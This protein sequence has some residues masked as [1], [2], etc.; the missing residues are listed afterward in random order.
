MTIKFFK[1]SLTLILLCLI[2][3]ISLV[4]FSLLMG[5]TSNQI[6]SVLSLILMFCFG[7]LYRS[8]W[9]G[10]ICIIF[11][12][13]MIFI[14]TVIYN[15]FLFIVFLVIAPILLMIANLIINYTRKITK[16]RDILITQ[17]N[18]KSPAYIKSNQWFEAYNQESTYDFEN[19]NISMLI[20]DTTINLTHTILPETTNIIAI[21]KAI[22]HTRIIVPIGVGISLMASSF[23]SN[24]LFDGE[25]YALK[26]EQLTLY[27]NNYIQ[28]SRKVKVILT[29]Y[30][31]DVE[32]IRL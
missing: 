20:G 16:T 23:Y 9:L 24:V 14:Q 25:N 21:Q 28:S 3:A 2:I 29:T 18:K 12:S 17:S 7:F 27:S 8:S 5:V 26:Q 13:F 4:F 6:I 32:I 10:K 31:G 30:I 1:K 22:G 19:I 11:S 15:T